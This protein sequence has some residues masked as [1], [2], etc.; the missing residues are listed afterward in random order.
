[1]HLRCSFATL[2]L[3]IVD[4]TLIARELK[5]TLKERIQM[6]DHHFSLGVIVAHETREIR[7]FVEL[8]QRFGRAIGVA[9]EVIHLGV[10]EQKTETLLHLLLH[11]TRDHDGLILQLPL[12]QTINFNSVLKLYP[13]SH[14]VDVLGDTAFQ[15]FK[16]DKLPFLPPVVAA[17]EEILRRQ[18]VR[19]A[20][21]HVLVVGE[22]RLVGAPAAVWAQRED[23]IVQTANSTTENFADLARNADVIILGAGVPGLLTA[24]M[25]K[26]GAI[27]LDAGTS[28]E[29]GVLKGD[30]DPAVAEKATVFTSTP[31]GIGP[32][33]VAKVF[34]NLLTLYQL[35]HHRT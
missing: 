34:E 17:M 31:G 12:P 4:G 25:V 18:G 9:V 13:L 15:Q 7:R 27:V 35:K 11:T 19:L 20:G 10:M 14:D 8:K 28:D 23:G 22:G 5:R 2:T 32:V 21:R 1:M 29:G 3:M 6:H 26:K 16:E 33:T 30:A 24:D